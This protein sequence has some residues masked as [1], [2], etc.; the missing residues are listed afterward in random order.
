M[1][2]QY[3]DIPTECSSKDVGFH[4]LVYQGKTTQ[5]G[6]LQRSLEYRCQACGQFITKAALQEATNVS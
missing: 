3:A 2:K 1:P 4:D 5:N 6:R